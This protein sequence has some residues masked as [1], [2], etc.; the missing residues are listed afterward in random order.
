MALVGAEEIV[1]SK[2]AADKPPEVQRVAAK[3]KTQLEAEKELF[4]SLL[5]T[6]I[7]SSKEPDLAAESQEFAEQVA[8]HF[9]LQYTT[10]GWGA[11]KPKFK[12]VE[13]TPA[14]VK[15]KVDLAARLAKEKADKVKTHSATLLSIL[16]GGLR[17]KRT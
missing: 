12:P 9:A 6:V 4:T 8:C 2:T 10:T 5:Q 11:P 3:T 13:L 17:P 7:A 1:A 14:E 16:R 15:A